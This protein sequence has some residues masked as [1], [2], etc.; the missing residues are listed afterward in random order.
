[1]VLLFEVF[2]QRKKLLVVGSKSSMLC[3][4][5][6]GFNKTVLDIIGFS[7]FVDSS[8]LVGKDQIKYF[9]SSTEN[10]IEPNVS[11]FMNTTIP[12]TLQSLNLCPK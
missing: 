1:M 7:I 9:T 10:Q 4:V 5:I 12:V 6:L 3:V 2:T 8:N 11:F